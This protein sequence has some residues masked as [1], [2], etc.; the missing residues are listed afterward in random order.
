MAQTIKSAVIKDD[1]AERLES[2]GLWRRAATR[3]LQVMHKIEYTA[4]EREWIRQRRIYCQSQITPV[5]VPASLSFADVTRA[6]NATQVRM[7]LDRPGGTAFRLL[8]ERSA[9][10]KTK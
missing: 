9:K 10:Q 2:L 4:S 5:A 1:I 3:W 7:G 8:P 6:A